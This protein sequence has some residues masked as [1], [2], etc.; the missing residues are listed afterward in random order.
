MDHLAEPR[1]SG[2]TAANSFEG[3]D[4]SRLVV[5]SKPDMFGLSHQV[6][7]SCLTVSTYVPT[8]TLC[9]ELLQFSTSKDKILENLLPVL[10]RK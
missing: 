7:C 2:V 3:E 6:L 9:V 5:V 8:D 10:Q 4:L 1:N